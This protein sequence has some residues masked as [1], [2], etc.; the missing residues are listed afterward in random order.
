L[1]R[2]DESIWND[3]HVNPFRAPA[4]YDQDGIVERFRRPER[5]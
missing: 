5:G 2:H 4:D 3:E 1:R